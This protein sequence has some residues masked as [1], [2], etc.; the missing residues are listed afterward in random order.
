MGHK[1]TSAP[2]KWGKRQRTRDRIAQAGIALF[3][4][5]GFDATTMEQ[6]A[7][8]ADVVRGT[9]YNHFPVKEA[10]VVYWLHA[11][12]AE[13]LGPL[14]TEA[15]ARS[16]FLARVATLLDASAQWWSQYRGFAAPYV[17]H[18]FQEVRED[19]GDEPTSDIIPAYALLVREGQASGELSPAID[20]DRLASYLH[21][22]TLCALLDW[23][24]D[25]KT[26]LAQRYADALEFFMEGARARKG[27]THH[28]DASR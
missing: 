9:L 15:M 23:V 19:Q 7:A 27:D 13:A 3:Q 1:T 17:R 16:S 18:R 8:A 22:L 21:F 10:I 24:A 4:A 26:G 25:P 28:P 12:L 11:Q 6:V 14:M 5:Q 20:A 2:G